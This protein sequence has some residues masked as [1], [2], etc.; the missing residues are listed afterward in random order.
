[1]FKVGVGTTALL[2]GLTGCG[3]ASTTVAPP[4]GEET[5]V[6]KPVTPP[7]QGDP[8]G[9]EIIARFKAKVPLT[10][11]VTG[12]GHSWQ[13]NPDGERDYCVSR[14]SLKHGS[15][16]EP[17]TMAAKVTEAK[18]KKVVGTKVIYNGRD[19]IRIKTFVFGFLAV[20]ATIAVDDPRIVDKYKR[21]FKDTSLDQWLAVLN[22]PNAKT[23]VIGGFSLRG[24]PLDLLEVKSKVSWKDVSKEIFG[25]SKRSDMPIYRDSYNLAGKVFK[26]IDME[27]LKTNVS[28]GSSEFELD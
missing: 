27:G 9:K 11:T 16:N 14:M 22:D 10:K 2:L 21:S 18:D 1:M 3:S 23:K 19:Q 26:H 13:V 4:K 6:L 15:V 5:P 24:E 25:V 7:D 28:F 12:T 8:E 20:K 17:F